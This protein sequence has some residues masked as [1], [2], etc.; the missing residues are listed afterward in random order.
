M[1]NDHDTKPTKKPL[2]NSTFL[3]VLAMED[4]R[5]RPA[6]IPD[7]VPDQKP[8]GPKPDGSLQK[9]DL[10]SG[11][12][13]PTRTPIRAITARNGHTMWE[14]LL[15]SHLWSNG[16]GDRDTRTISAG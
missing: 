1:E 15:Y 14:Q 10:D 8:A 5:R 16:I 11:A 2:V 4:R 3:R 9:P 13:R 6:P 7:P 12:S